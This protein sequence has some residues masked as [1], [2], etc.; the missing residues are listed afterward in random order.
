M[1][2]S[3]VFFLQEVG[4]GKQL[5][6]NVISMEMHM[7][8]VICDWSILFSQLPDEFSNL[9]I[10]LSFLITFVLFLLFAIFFLVLL[11]G[12]HSP[13]SPAMA[14][15]MFLKC[16]HPLRRGMKWGPLSLPH[17]PLAPVA[18][19]PPYPPGKEVMA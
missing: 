9:H 8:I 18:P 3:A 1:L 6:E 7:R 19:K 5:V 16:G 12:F 17:P 11:A 13:S 2:F 4:I 10:Q 14:L 15:V